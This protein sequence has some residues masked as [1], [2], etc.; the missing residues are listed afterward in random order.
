[1]AYVVPAEPK[2]YHIIHADRLASVLQA[3]CLWSDAEMAKNPDTGT[4]IGMNRIKQ[5]RLR[6][7]KLASHPE[8]FVGDCVPFYFC[9]RSVMLYLIWR[10]NDS[11]LAYTGGED[12]IVHL[13]ADLHEVVKWADEHD[14][15]W[16]FT[17]SNAG[18]RGFEDRASLQALDEVNWPAVAATQWAGSLQHG[19]Q[20]EFLIQGHFPW[21][22]VR[23]IGVRSQ[24]TGNTVTE[25]LSG[26][27]HR[28][29]VQIIKGWYYG[30]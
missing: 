4:V 29:P 5:R 8:L 7:L 21:S 10:A 17:L 6:E 11:D 23:R 15:R 14:Q 26:H 20:A 25:I 30:A 28:P 13:E 22:L 1:M 18:G 2:I 3:N 19:K 9:P 16:A 27:A 24:A 12:P